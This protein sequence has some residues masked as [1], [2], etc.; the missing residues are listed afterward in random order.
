MLISLDIAVTA[1]RSI[2]NICISMWC[3][4]KKDSIYKKCML[5]INALVQIRTSAKQC[6]SRSNSNGGGGG[7]IVL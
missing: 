5:D 7:G 4:R 1:V 3:L 2:I 6:W